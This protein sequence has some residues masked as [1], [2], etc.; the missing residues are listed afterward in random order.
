[1][2]SIGRISELAGSGPA[3]LAAD[4]DWP[5]IRDWRRKIRE[6]LIAQRVAISAEDR[7]AWSETIGRA[8]TAALEPYASSLIGFYWPFRGEYDPRGV[9]T[10]MRERGSRL[11]LP[12]IVERGQPL[13][14]RLW[15]PG[16]LMVQGIWKIPMP[17]SG[18]AV[19]PDLLVVP[20]VGFDGQ[21]YRLG[22]GGGFY[23]RTIATMPER[24]RTVG[25]GF[26]LGRLETICPQPHDI[27]LE[28]IITER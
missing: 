26:E 15:S 16:S 14:F 8:L 24:P 9:L 12:V 22:Y 3:L 6:K 13:V 5:T 25:V 11:A 27:P 10:A 18:E 1:M 28:Q 23:D 7:S 20:L 21:G 2:S 19:F 4:A 17:E